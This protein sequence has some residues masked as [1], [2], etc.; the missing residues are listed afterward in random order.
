MNIIYIYILKCKYHIFS[1]I[2]LYIQVYIYYIYIIY[3]IIHTP[4]RCMY[5]STYLIYF[6]SIIIFCFNIYKIPH[7]YYYYSTN[8]ITHT[9]A[10]THN[11]ITIHVTLAGLC[12]VC[13]SFHYMNI[14][15]SKKLKEHLEN[16]SDLNVK[17]YYV[18]YLYWYGQFNVLGTKGCHIFWWKYK[19]SAYRGLNCI[20][21][22]KI[23]WKN[24]VAG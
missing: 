10:H 21:T 11:H 6:Y 2:I 9:H 15:C 12:Y 19:F 22:P 1:Y 13:M 8:T 7:I 23:K 20:D 14:H 4:Y 16:T 3:Y 18:G 17:K 24:Y 5:V